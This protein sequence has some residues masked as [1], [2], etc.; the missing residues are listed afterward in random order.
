[1]KNSLSM[2][3][4]QS[5]TI[6]KHVSYLKVSNNCYHVSSLIDMVKAILPLNIFVKV[7]L[8][9]SSNNNGQ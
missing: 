8:T 6:P 9:C 7:F 1:M 3:K 2:V 5:F 4:C